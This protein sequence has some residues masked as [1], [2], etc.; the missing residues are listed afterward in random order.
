MNT[1]Q[2]KHYIIKP[3]FARSTGIP[4]SFVANK[5]K[6]SARAIF[7]Y[8]RGEMD[9]QGSCAKCG[10]TLTHPGSILIGIGPVC[11][12]DWGR[13][14]IVLENITDA[15]KEELQ[16]HIRMQEINTWIPKSVIKKEF[17]TDQVVISPIIPSGKPTGKIRGEEHTTVIKD[18]AVKKRARIWKGVIAIQFPYNLDLI[19]QVKTLPMGR[20]YHPKG[21]YWSC[22]ISREAVQK[23]R[24][25]GYVLDDELIELLR[26]W[27]VKSKGVTVK[28]VRVVGK[29]VR[30]FKK[31][32]FPF[33][34][35]GLAFLEQKNGRALLADEMGLGK[36][37]QSLAYLQLHPDKRLAIIVCPASLK[38]NW[39]KEIR[40]GLSTNDTVEILQGKTPYK[41]DA[42]IVIINYDILAAWADF[43]KKAKPLIIISDECHYFKNNKSLRTKAIKK[44]AKGVPHFIAL[45]GTPVV[46]RPIEMYNA[47]NIIDPY[48]IPNFWIYAKQ[49]CG[50]KHNGF[51]WDFGGASN[52]EE[53]HKLLCDSIM[54]RRLKKDVLKDLPDKVRSFVPIR[55]N[56][57]N[58]YERVENNF[59]HFIKETKGAE[60]AE[61]VSTA[62]VL[63]QI[64]YLKQAAVEGKMDSVI[65][66]ITDFLET[67]NK[68][69]V[70]ATHKVAINRLMEFFGN[71]AVKIDGSVSTDNRDKAVTSFQEDDKICLFVGNIKAAGLGLT[72]TAASNVAFIELPWTPGELSQAEDRC[73]RIGQKDS[74]NIYYLLAERTI[75]DEI[76]SLLDSK[77]KVL[78]AVLDGKVTEDTSL[79]SELINKYKS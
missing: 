68:L 34:E 4:A 28:Q 9:P 36:T 77:R 74:V 33:Q 55:L 7:V 58:L 53:L 6:E 67:G 65:E 46:N 44:L 76:A 8:G 13:R 64:E 61:R 14:D 35:E 50:A 16:A 21:K 66:W 62:Q 18:E 15:Q 1:K 57:R 54:I 23:L 20:K 47:I 56:N 38:L 17:E 69:V 59:I 71:I 32:L 60:A 75:E 51:G 45:S 43:L 3:L 11:L 26:C 52:M 73:H 37:I 72:L 63:V 49:Y 79:L 5:I 29:K 10:R 19:T 24:E 22:P 39:K 25:W 41:F 70:F 12:G 40:D 48:L 30:A 31:K 27:E 42:S 78:D 2:T